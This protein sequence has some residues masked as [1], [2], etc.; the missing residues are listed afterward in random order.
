MYDLFCLTLKTYF[1]VGLC[2]SMA[3]SFILA[4]L[5]CQHAEFLAAYILMEPRCAP[6]LPIMG[7][8]VP[9]AALHACINGYYYGNQ[10]ANVPAFSQVAELTVVLKQKH[11]AYNN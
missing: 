9:F 6:F 4:F 2:I 10:K 8:S 3:F 11:G 5:I 1:R 7:I